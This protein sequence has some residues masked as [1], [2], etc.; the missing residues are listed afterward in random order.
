M[1]DIGV[2]LQAQIDMDFKNQI[3]QSSKLIEI[4]KRI[5]ARTATQ[6]DVVD[7]S[8]IT[9]EIA[10]QVIRDNLSSINFQTTECIVILQKRQ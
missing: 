10:S 6:A 1:R 9:G 8:K 3:S 7:I 2:E 4:Y 5:D